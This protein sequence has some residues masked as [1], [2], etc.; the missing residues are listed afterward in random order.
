MGAG[1]SVRGGPVPVPTSR[2]TASHAAAAWESELSRG[3]PRAHGRGDQSRRGRGWGLREDISADGL[4]QRGLSQGEGPLATPS[5][6]GMGTPA[7]HAASCPHQVYVPT[8]FEKYTASFR[9]RGKPAKIH[10]WDTAGGTRGAAPCSGQPHMAPPRLGG[11]VGFLRMEPGCDGVASAGAPQG[12]RT[13]TG[14]AR[15]P[16]Q[17]PTLSSY[18]SMSPAAAAMTT[19]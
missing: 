6:T 13:T 19:S 14:C 8:V 10:L 9:I 15:C 12:R 11:Q 7:P 16:T 1:C 5:S 18:A 3:A 17:T 4:C 2:P